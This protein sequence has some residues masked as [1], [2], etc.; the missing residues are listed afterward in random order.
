MRKWMVLVVAGWAGMAMAAKPV[1]A[2]KAAAE[3]PVVATELVLRH[4]LEGR[5]LDTLAT[6]TLRFNE[7]Q[8]G[9]GRIVLQ[10]LS[11]VEKKGDLPDLA[12]L[13]PDDAM[14]FFETLPRYLP[15]AKVMA[16]GGGKLDAKQF[17]P[18]VA[19]ATDDTSGKML[20][21][22]VGLS[23]PVLLWNKDAFHKAGLDPE[24]PPKTWWEVQE[25]AGKLFDAG[26]KCPITSSR[27][28][29]VHVESASSQA[30]EPIIVKPNRV[31]LNALIN[32]KHLALLA[33]WQKSFYFRYYGPN[34]ESDARFLSG[35]CA[36][37]TGESRLYAEA[38][39]R[40]LNVGL[41]ALPYYDDVYTAAP[42][43]VR[44]QGAGIWVLAGLKK[45]DARLVAQYVEFLMRPEVQ[46]EW[47]KGTGYLPMTHQAMQALREGGAPPALMDAA[48][49]RLSAPKVVVPKFGGVM[50]RLHEVLGE[51]VDAVWRNEKPAKAALDSAMQR[52]N[53]A[54]AK[55]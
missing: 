5:A 9:K 20:A 13:H 39:A 24:K 55:K 31:A 48:E 29:W 51:E 16:D 3:K 7:A 26:S 32:V 18:Q 52:V 35:E 38:V 33:S 40:K 22:P 41:A 42:G 49:R 23:L 11:G 10:S 54:P 4:A 6:L 14:S 27:F 21:L 12:L 30:A 50:E 2:P 37:Q 47:V 1:K 17:Y 43:N 44:P 15:L 19:D 25:V 45:S 34:L 28:A 46:R 8:Q 36:M 53:A